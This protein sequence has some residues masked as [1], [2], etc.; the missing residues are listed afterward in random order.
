[1]SMNEEFKKDLF[2]LNN[3][4]IPI[5]TTMQFKNSNDELWQC[6]KSIIQEEQLENRKLEL[7]VEE[8][9][10]QQISILR[11]ASEKLLLVEGN[12]EEITMKT[13]TFEDSHLFIK[14]LKL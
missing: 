13:K 6:S 11:V 2:I 8:L 9:H 4:C 3:L 12:L 10:K 14:D 1:M 5:Q 7:Q